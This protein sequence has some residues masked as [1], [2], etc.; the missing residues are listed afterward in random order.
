MSSGEGARSAVLGWL[1]TAGSLTSITVRA[2]PCSRSAR[3]AVVTAA[4]GAESSRTNRIRAAGTAGSIGTYVAPVLS[5]ASIATIAS[6]LRGS[7]SATRRPAPTPWAASRCA[8]R[9]AASFSL[10]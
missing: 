10:R 9:F 1:S 4:T 2:H 6:A 7:N 8:S 3:P 5:T